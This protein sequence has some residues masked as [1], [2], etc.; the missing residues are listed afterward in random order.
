M[1]F[2]F[3]SINHKKSKCM[4]ISKSETHLTCSLELGDIKIE[5]VDNFNYLGS[6]VTSNGRCK[7]E[8]LRPISLAKKGLQEN[9]GY[10]L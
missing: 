1:Q 2:Q 6:V 3:L 9:E 10:P 5:Q 4:V 8:I 7:K